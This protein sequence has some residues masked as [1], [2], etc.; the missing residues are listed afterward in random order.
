MASDAT[1]KTPPDPKR[2]I[3]VCPFCGVSAGMSERCS[4]CGGRFDALSRQATQNEMGPWVIRDEGQ[5]FRPG[6]RFETLCRLVA[7]GRVARDTVLRGPST[8]QFWL[9][10]VRVPGVARLFGVCHSCG[11]A[12]AEAQHSCSACGAALDFNHDRQ[13]LGLGA[14]RSI[15]DDPGP[16]VAID[17]VIEPVIG[18]VI[19]PSSEPVT[20]RSRR[21][22]SSFG[23]VLGWVVAGALVLVLIGM[24][25]RSSG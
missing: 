17:P 14:Q 24:M 21:R 8:Y 2:Q 6:C 4:A 22:G 11:Q 18:P 1:S 7:S 13:F 23:A 20:R 10:A 5:P 16:P 3:P 9:R 12:V 15:A 25:T 19:G